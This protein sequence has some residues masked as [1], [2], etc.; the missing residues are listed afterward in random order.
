MWIDQRGSQVLQPPECLWLLAN[1]AGHAAVGRIGVCGDVAPIVLP[2]NFAYSQNLILVL[3]GDGFLGTQATDHMV[4]FETDHVD[5]DTSTAWSVLV[6]GLATELSTWHD[7]PHLTLPRPLVP[8]PGERL[9]AIR[10][11]MITG[12]RFTASS[13]ER[14]SPSEGDSPGPGAS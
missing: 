3:V 2:V 8:I 9:L 13:A 10:P 5:T 4:A 7:D 14:S 11:D 6:R 1:A 12:R